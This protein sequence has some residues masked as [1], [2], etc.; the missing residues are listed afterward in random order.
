MPEVQTLAH[1]INHTL[2]SVGSTVD[3]LEPVEFRPEIETDSLRSW[4]TT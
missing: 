2:G 1:A 3:Y 4:S